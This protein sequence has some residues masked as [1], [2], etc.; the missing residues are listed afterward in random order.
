MKRVEEMTHLM[1]TVETQPQAFHS[2][3]QA[4]GNLANSARFPHSLSSDH[5]EWKWKTQPAFAHSRAVP[6][7]FESQWPVLQPGQ[8]ITLTTSAS[9]VP[10]LHPYLTQPRLV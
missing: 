6:R 7:S 10:G 8:T 3:P 4:L 1:E 2:F 9:R 5:Y